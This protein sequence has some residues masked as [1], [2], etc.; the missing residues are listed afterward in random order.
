MPVITLFIISILNSLFF[1]PIN[2]AVISKP[3]QN[4]CQ[5][6]SPTDSEYSDFYKAIVCG[7][8]DLP[9][10]TIWDFKVVGLFHLIVVSGSHLVF[11]TYFLDKIFFLKKS[12]VV[13]LIKF[14]ILF[15]YAL[16][17]GL[18][19]PIIRALASWVISSLNEQYKL[20]WSPPY[21]VLV[22]GFFCLGLF[23][24]WWSSLSFFMS[25]CAAFGL[26]L[27]QSPLKK[28][29]FIYFFMALPMSGLGI[30]SPLTILTNVFIAPV[31]GFVMLP[32][33]FL[34]YVVPKVIGVTDFAW[35]IFNIVI[36][37]L[38]QWMPSFDIQF[39][40]PQWALWFIFMFLQVGFIAHDVYKKRQ[41]F[42]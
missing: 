7:V 28:C 24:S 33:S 41:A 3:F 42:R 34:P 26:S 30:S 17:S 11:L 39:L 19:A 35:R 6:M 8:L 25:W 4:F 10:H 38:A 27:G 29:I 9:Q 32:I 22:T 2:T 18:N 1:L 12:K 40:S 37:H 16:T 15:L 14:L 36:S 23:P 31:I 21:A 5:K 13:F 20:A